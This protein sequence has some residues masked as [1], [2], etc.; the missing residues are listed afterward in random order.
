MKNKLIFIL[1]L[2]ASNSLWAGEPV[3]WGYTQMIMDSGVKTMDCEKV[4]GGY[5]GYLKKMKDYGNRLGMSPCTESNSQGFN[6]NVIMCPSPQ[7]IGNGITGFWF[8]DKAACEAARID[9]KKNDG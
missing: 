9:S 3:S 4:T 5:K 7:R 2:L 8:K 6:T 1:V